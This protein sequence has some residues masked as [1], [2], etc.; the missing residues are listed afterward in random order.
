MSIRVAYVGRWESAKCSLSRPN[1]III[2]RMLVKS[3]IDKALAVPWSIA[4]LVLF[5]TDSSLYHQGLL[6]DESL[7]LFDMI[8]HS[9]RS[10]IYGRPRALLLTSSGNTF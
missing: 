9:L 5:L 6:S 3:T 7:A 2:N 8:A 10:M 1:T 4:H